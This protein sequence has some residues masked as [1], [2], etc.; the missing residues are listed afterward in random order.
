MDEDV[1]A[2]ASP[3]RA[4]TAGEL[5]VAAMD[6]STATLLRCDAALRAGAADPDVVH[7]ARVALR[8]MRS[9]VQTFRPI[10]D[11]AWASRV[12]ER[13]RWLAGG[14]GAARDADVLLARVERCAHGMRHLD[15]ERKDHVVALLRGVR[16]NAYRQLGA[17]TREAR[18][19]ALIDDLVH[20]ASAPH[21]TERAG[22][23]AG[24]LVPELMQAAWRRLRA[25]NRQRSHPPTD[26]D[27]HAIRIKAKRVRYAAEAVMPAAGGSAL[28]F[29]KRV[30]RLQ[31][32]LGEHRDAL[33][34]ADQLHAHVGG[35]D[36]AFFAAEVAAR[37]RAAARV[38]RRRWRAAWNRV[39]ADDVRFWHA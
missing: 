18:Y 21:L 2:A 16:V 6:E 19:A 8:R 7:A 24:A 4:L 28:R 31:T 14:L 13:A 1:P 10:L 23:D 36:G 33:M 30:A 5:F 15:R 32:V 38:E 11:P 25:T 27:L 17:M 20:A 39:A 29:A 34:S 26:A 22:E 35:G 12:R 37:E 3:N 9:N